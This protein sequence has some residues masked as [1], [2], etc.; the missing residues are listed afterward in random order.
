M[1]EVWDAYDING[2]R[3]GFELYRDEYANIPDGVYHIVV[4][5]FS[6]T[7]D[8]RVLVTQRH[9][10]KTYPLKWENTGGSVLKGETSVQG[11]IRELREETGIALTQDQ[12][13]YAYT[14]HGPHAL[15]ECF[16]ALIDDD[17]KITLQDGE[18]IDYKLLPYNEFMEFIRTV[19]FV[20]KISESIQN[21]EKD[22]LDALE[23]IKARTV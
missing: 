6:F 11:A 22:I 5:I 23:R 9:A 8:G 2:Q 21:H 13:E 17:V 4:E 12:I 16:T 10:G 18:T 1:R 15:H 20:D 3:L 7:M 19:A 14:E